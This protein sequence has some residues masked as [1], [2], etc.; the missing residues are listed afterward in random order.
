MDNIIK[1][2]GTPSR[3]VISKTDS[4]MIND[5]SEQLSALLACQQYLKLAHLLETSFA[6]H[7]ALGESYDTLGGLFDGLIESIQGIYGLKKLSIPETTVYEG[8]IEYV[9]EAYEYID[10]IRYSFKESWIQSELDM[11][12]KELAHL[13]YKLK[14]LN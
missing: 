13:L 7:I 2:L 1:K 12:Q 14:F 5:C 10:K 11:I 3:K 6:K 4:V 9:T 8:P